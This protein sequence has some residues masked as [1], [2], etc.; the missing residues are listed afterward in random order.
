MRACFRHQKN[1]VPAALEPCSHPNLCLAPAI[2][3]TVV[4]EG[5]ATIH[6]PVNDLHGRFL[7]GSFAQ[8]MAPEPEY[9]DLGV[10][11]SELAKSNGS[12]G[13]LRHEI[14]LSNLIGRKC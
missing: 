11:A 3:P 10:S 13:T 2:L 1:L 9:G 4:V 6:R 5:D 8:V 7:I 14:F 12:A